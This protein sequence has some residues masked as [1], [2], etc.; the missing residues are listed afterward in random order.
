MDNCWACSRNDLVDQ[1]NPSVK[2]LSSM[3]S[4][5]LRSCMFVPKGFNL[6]QGFPPVVSHPFHH[7]TNLIVWGSGLWF[8]SVDLK[9]LSRVVKS[10]TRV[11]PAL[12]AQNWFGLW[13]DDISVADPEINLQRGTRNSCQFPTRWSKVTVP[14]EAWSTVKFFY[15]G[16]TKVPG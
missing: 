14:T 12:P 2:H 9:T 5:V 10:S 16:R 13:Y 8:H 11:N 1:Q 15:V 3:N 4:D 6:W 7:K